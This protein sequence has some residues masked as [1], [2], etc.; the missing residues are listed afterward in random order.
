MNVAEEEHPITAEELI[1][2]P[3]FNLRKSAENLEIDTTGLSDS[4]VKL[5]IINKIR[6]SC[7][8]VSYEIV[9]RTYEANKNRQHKRH[10]EKA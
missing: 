2:S 3:R 10:P 6:Y 8:A 7:K 1:N 5:K 9:G 4:E